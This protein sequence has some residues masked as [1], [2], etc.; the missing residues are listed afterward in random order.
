MHENNKSPQKMKKWAVL[1]QALAMLCQ[2]Q[3]M[4]KFSEAADQME[5][6]IAPMVIAGIITMLIF[7]ILCMT[8][9][10]FALK[11]AGL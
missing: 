4:K 5:H 2:I 7:F 1:K 10:Y 8:A 11:S 9:V 3:S 6:S